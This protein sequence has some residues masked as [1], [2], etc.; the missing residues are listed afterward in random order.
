MPS[1]LLAVTMQQRMN[2]AKSV[3]FWCLNPGERKHTIK[4]LT[5]KVGAMKHN[6]KQRN[7]RGP[8]MVSLVVR[9]LRTPL[10]GGGVGAEI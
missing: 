5:K 3:G 2:T 6:T 4:K 8:G 7:V 9:M 10:L 1:T